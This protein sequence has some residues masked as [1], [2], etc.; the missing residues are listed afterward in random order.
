VIERARGR[1]EAQSLAHHEVLIPHEPNP[2]EQRLT[3]LN[4]DLL[5]TDDST[6]RG[7]ILDSIYDTELQLDTD[8]TAEETKRRS[9]LILA[10]SSANSVH[11]SFLSSMSWTVLT[12]TRSH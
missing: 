3:K 1:V 7:H 2:A 11:P 5:N 9:L 10:N 8:S 4:I 6:A 12:P